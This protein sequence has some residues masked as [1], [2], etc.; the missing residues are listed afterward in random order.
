[1][2]ATTWQ[3]NSLLKAAKKAKND[4]SSFVSWLHLR[5]LAGLHRQNCCVAKRR[6][7]T[8][9]LNIEAARFCRP[10]FLL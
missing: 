8:V 5:A 9:F 7:V 3:E 2:Q 6:V 1:M 4:V 10:I